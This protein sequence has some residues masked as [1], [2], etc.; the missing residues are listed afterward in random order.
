MSSKRT[1]YAITK[2]VPPDRQGSTFT[3]AQMIQS[4]MKREDSD[5]Y[6]HHT[7]DTHGYFTQN[8]KVGWDCALTLP[9]LRTYWNWGQRLIRQLV[10]EYTSSMKIRRERQRRMGSVWPTT[11][12]FS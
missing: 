4:P 1:Q 2:L 9:T 11:C 6:T 12:R 7:H 5:T 3:P 10:V 8:K